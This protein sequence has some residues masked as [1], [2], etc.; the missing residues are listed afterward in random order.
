MTLLYHRLEDHY[1]KYNQR[2]WVHPDPLEFLYTYPDI[3]DREIV[4]LIASALAY[5]NVKQILKSTAKVL[6]EL[7]VSPYDF[8]LKNNY[9]KIEKLFAGFKHR[10]TTSFELVEF[11]SAIKKF[12]SHYGSMENAFLTG[13]DDSQETVLP[14]L[15]CFVEKLYN[16][17]RLD[18]NSLLPIPAKGSACKRLNLFLRWMARKDAVDPGGW[19]N[20]PQSKLIVPLDVHMHRISVILKLTSNRHNS[21][22]TALEITKNFA[23]LSPDDPVKYDF[24]LTRIGIQKIEMEIA[25][26]FCGENLKGTCDVAIY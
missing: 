17:M 3:K 23:V 4:G 25:P 7:S 9:G 15:T 22:K 11:L 19:T 24:S 20:V 2:K 21:M 5:G 14:A 1:I 10:F 12:L 18:K 8:L 13:Y 6:A 26:Y 16:H